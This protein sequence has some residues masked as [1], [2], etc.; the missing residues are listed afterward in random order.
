MTFIEKAK[1]KRMAYLAAGYTCTDIIQT[2]TFAK[3]TAKDQYGVSRE[4]LFG[5]HG[6]TTPLLEKVKVVTP[7][8]VEEQPKPIKK[9]RKKKGE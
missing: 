7:E 3:F 1:S 8:V 6:V 5:E 9:S 4:M 2:E